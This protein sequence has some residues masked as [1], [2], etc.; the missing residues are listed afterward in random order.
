MGGGYRDHQDDEPDRTTNQA[1]TPAVSQNETTCSR[2][3]PHMNSFHL[4]NSWFLVLARQG[5]REIGRP[6]QRNS[7]KQQHNDTDPSHK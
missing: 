7:A 6:Q 3:Y 2:A 1:C 5:K 4:S